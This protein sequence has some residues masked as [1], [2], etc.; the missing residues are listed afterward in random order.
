MGSLNFAREVCMNK[1]HL[2]ARLSLLLAA[3]LIL[4]SCLGYPYDLLFP[5]GNPPAQNAPAQPD[6]P[7]SPPEQAPAVGADAASAYS[8]YGPACDS[9]DE[10][11]PYRWQVDLILDS[12]TNTY[13]GSL[14]FHDCPG[15]GRAIYRVT[16]PNLNADQ[17]SLTGVLKLGG[18]ALFDSAPK[19]ATFSFNRQTGKVEPN[20]AP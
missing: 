9:D 1:N 8:V 16:A 17:L 2:F 5:A 4:S 10:G 14:A 12:Q 7:A 6:N 20:L 3:G 13:A 11:Y 18:G 19:Q 15:G